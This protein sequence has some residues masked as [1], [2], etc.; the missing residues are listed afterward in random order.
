LENFLSKERMDAS[1]VSSVYEMKQE[2]GKGAFSVVYLA[3]NKNT[4]EKVAIKIID[5][6]ET[7]QEDQKRL[8][9]EVEILK[10]VKH[11]NI[12]CM[13]DLFDTPDK[14]YL[15]IE[16]VTGGE[17]FDK[18]VEKG[19][20][21]AV[22]P[23]RFVVDLPYHGLWSTP[24]VL[25][26]ACLQDG[27]HTAVARARHRC[28][29]HSVGSDRFRGDALGNSAHGGRPSLKSRARA[30]GAASYGAYALFREHL[31]TLGIVSKPVRRSL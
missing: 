19:P 26:R 23:A 30:H 25:A 4:G 21:R 17:L 7:K 24:V 1:S 11:P 14:L 15:V 27:T 31:G 29:A 13:K 6:H 3:V 5:K 2:L 12:I 18:I 16:L 10:R 8:K 22:C 9:T 20:D 28:V